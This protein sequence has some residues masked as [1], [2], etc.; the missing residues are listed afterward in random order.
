[1][2]VFA[3]GFRLCAF[4]HQ[5][6]LTALPVRIGGEPRWPFGQG[7]AVQRFM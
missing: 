6:E 2:I 7:A 5:N 4:H 1:M 3:D